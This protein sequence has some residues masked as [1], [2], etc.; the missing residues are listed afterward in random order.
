M[1]GGTGFGPRD[2]TPEATLSIL[3]RSA[4]GLIHCML[5][6]SLSK[7]PLAALSRPAAG[8][9]GATIIVNLPG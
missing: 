5:S 3:E 7:T 6:G 2:V 1:L 8:T 9:R 4:P